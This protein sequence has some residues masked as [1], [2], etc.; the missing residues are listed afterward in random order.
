MPATTVPETRLAALYRHELRWARTIRALEPAAFAGSCLQYPLVWSAL[1]LLL[2]AGAPWAAILFLAAWIL[3]ALAA[4]GVDRALA[5]FLSGVAFPA[6][7]WLLPLRELMSV[8][9]MIASYGGDRV[10]WRGH[11]LRADG[12][13]SLSIPPRPAP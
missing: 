8:V 6:S 13:V 2:S 3:R 10:D 5:R 1:A 11:S 12:P 7:F 4:R 9:V